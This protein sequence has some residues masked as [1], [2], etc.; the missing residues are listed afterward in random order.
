VQGTAA[1]GAAAKALSFPSAFT[2]IVVQN[3]LV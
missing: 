2:M 3:S 1:L